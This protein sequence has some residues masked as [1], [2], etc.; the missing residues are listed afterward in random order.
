MSY[1]SYSYSSTS[2]GSTL[3][4]PRFHQVNFSASHNRSIYPR[5]CRAQLL[6]IWCKMLFLLGRA[7]SKKLTIPMCTSCRIF[8]KLLGGL[9]CPREE[10]YSRTPLSSCDHWVSHHQCT[11]PSQTISHMWFT[12]HHPSDDHTPCWANLVKHPQIWCKQF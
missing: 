7:F 12:I 6:H 11:N 5:L 2:I 1:S 10:Y 4:Q 3:L 8:P 9:Q